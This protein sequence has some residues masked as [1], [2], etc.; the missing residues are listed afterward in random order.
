MDKHGNNPSPYDTAE[1]RH[2]LGEQ[3]HSWG[4]VAKHT[5][6]LDQVLAAIAQEPASDYLHLL[7][8]L[9]AWLAKNKVPADIVAETTRPDRSFQQ[10]VKL[11]IRIAQNSQDMPRVSRVRPIP[12]L[13]AQDDF[14]TEDALGPALLHSLKTRFGPAKGYGIRR[15]A[16]GVVEP[17]LAKVIARWALDPEAP[18]ILGRYS[19]PDHPDQENWVNISELIAGAPAE[20]RVRLLQADAAQLQQGTFEGIEHLNERLQEATGASQA[21]LGSIRLFHPTP[22]Y[23]AQIK[24]KLLAAQTPAV[25][26]RA[27]PRRRA[28]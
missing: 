2:F 12:N 21:T 10:L 9:R 4:Q 15:G 8:G 5:P 3:L 23:Q 14:H 19:T 27:S 11:G 18:I 25:G 17:L 26:G 1:N 22:A 16:L 28:L 7:D 20:D 6:L 24:A 13:E